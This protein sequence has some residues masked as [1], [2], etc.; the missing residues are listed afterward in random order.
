MDEV[1]IKRKIGADVASIVGL[2]T[3]LLLI[4]VVIFLGGSVR[5]FVNIPG[6]IIVVGGTLAGTVLSFRAKDLKA[7]LKAFPVIFKSKTELPSDVMRNM[8]RMT[9]VSRKQGLLKLSKFESESP[10]LQK[11]LNI[12]TDNPTVSRFRRTMRI[13]IEALKERHFRVQNVYKRM[14]T[15][16]PA[17]GM[18]G[19]V[20]GLI[21]MLSRLDDPASIGPAMAV[22]LLTTFYGSF[23][24]TMIFLPIANKLRE[25][26]MEEVYN[27]EIILEGGEA[28]LEGEHPV[29]VYEKLSSFVPPSQRERY[30]LKL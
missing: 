28:L 7:A 9:M 29:F 8:L 23:L 17:F 24:S 10:Y 2:T 11:V 20:I 25:I 16:A 21:K 14:G 27:M 19:T 12:L 26:T 13:E 5:N 4:V 22:A 1:V 6:V 15:L 30:S 18:L 3:G